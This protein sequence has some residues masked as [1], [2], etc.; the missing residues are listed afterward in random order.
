M[1]TRRIAIVLEG[2]MIQSV[3]TDDPSLRD[4]DVMVIDYDTDGADEQSIIH[5]PQPDGHYNPMEEA[6]AYF[7]TIDASALDLED[8]QHRIEEKE[9]RLN[10]RDQ[11]DA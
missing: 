2:G 6:Y 1:S 4:V 11:A 8:V 9:R 10:E 5:V 3:I 7:E